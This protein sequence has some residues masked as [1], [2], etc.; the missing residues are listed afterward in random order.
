MSELLLEVVV[1]ALDVLG[2]GLELM[3]GDLGDLPGHP[4]VAAGDRR[5][6][7]EEL[8]ALVRVGTQEDR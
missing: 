3:G 5:H 7:A 4:Q 8:D 2:V 1:G 6:L